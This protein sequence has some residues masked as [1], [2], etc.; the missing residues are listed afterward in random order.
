[1]PVSRMGTNQ[2]EVV[3]RRNGLTQRSGHKK[4]TQPAVRQGCVGTGSGA[5]SAS[6]GKFGGEDDV[7]FAADSHAIYH[8]GRE[9][10]GAEGGDALGVGEFIVG[11]CDD[12]NRGRLTLRGQ[13][14]RD[15][16]LGRRARGAGDGDE[17]DLRR[18]EVERLAVIAAEALVLLGGSGSA[19]EDERE[20]GGEQPEEESVKFHECRSIKGKQQIG[21]TTSGPKFWEG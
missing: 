13:G 5:R 17:V 7:L 11:A 4:K 14:E 12:A 2:S 20:A 6:A 9:T 16:K 21:K 3:C 10:G 8:L 18:I 15:F 1:M 19:G